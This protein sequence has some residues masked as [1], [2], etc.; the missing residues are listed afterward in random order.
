MNTQSHKTTSGHM[1][2][3]QKAAS[4]ANMSQ[5]STSTEFTFIQYQYSTKHHNSIR[6]F[7]APV[8]LSLTAANDTVTLSDEQIIH[9][10]CATM[11]A[12][13]SSSRYLQ[14]CSPHSGCSIL[15][16]HLRFGSVRFASVRRE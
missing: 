10:Q 11:N 4:H 3:S 8:C 5:A 16:T 13:F 9:L 14:H 1:H 7:C 15:L 12:L 2:E 6:A